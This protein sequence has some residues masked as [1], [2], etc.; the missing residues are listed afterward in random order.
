MAST[1]FLDEDLR[2]D[3]DESTV[4]AIVGGSLE[5]N[6]VT[7]TTEVNTSLQQQKLHQQQEQ[8]EQR[9]EFQQN[10]VNINN[11]LLNSNQDNNSSSAILVTNGGPILLTSST[12]QNKNQQQ[13]QHTFS[14][15]SE[16][17][18]VL[19]NNN[20][21]NHNINNN[22]NNNNN[23]SSNTSSSNS[24]NIINSNS[25]NNNNNNNT[26]SNKSEIAPGLA[27]FEASKSNDISS[28]DSENTHSTSSSS[29]ATPSSATWNA[30]SIASEHIVSNISSSSSGRDVPNLYT[31]SQQD[32]SKSH[33]NPN[34]FYNVADIQ[35][36]SRPI[37]SQEQQTGSV[38]SQ[39]SIQS[40]VVTNTTVSSTPSVSDLVR[41]QPPIGDTGPAVP[42]SQHIN[43]SQQHQQHLHHQQHQLQQHQLRQA[44]QIIS[45]PNL[46][47][48]T[49]SK[50]NEP[51]KL[52]YPSSVG[53]SQPAVLMNNRVTFTSQ[54]LPNGTINL[55]TLS[56]QQQQNI[57]HTSTSMTAG[58]GTNTVTGQQQ[59]TIVIKNQVRLK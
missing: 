14:V 53:S 59:Q 19:Q 5:T 9:Q 51:V 23:N 49:M 56:S 58:T 21:N 4:S 2:T 22:S 57:M 45:Q 39:R 33:S 41:Q 6:L 34:E 20:N 37:S 11:N 1:K 47:Q 30:S 40:P 8:N 28:N 52:V 27:S 18:N 26:A 50:N 25:N 31:A 17:N 10:F 15:N 42:I 46:P 16:S 55:A 32:S 29:L 7:A 43:T 48:S 35:A 36:H 13:Q 12:T 3:V 24:N 38:D 54:S 44:Q